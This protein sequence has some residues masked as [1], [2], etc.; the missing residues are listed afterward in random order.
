MTAALATFA[1]VANLTE[2]QAYTLAVIVRRNMKDDMTM[3]QAVESYMHAM[4]HL[5]SYARG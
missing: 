5:T 3:E 2:Q 1:Q 4:G